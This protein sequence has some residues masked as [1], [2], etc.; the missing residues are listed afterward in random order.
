MNRERGFSLVELL[1]VITIIGILA[2]I[3]LPN[4]TKVRIKARETEVKANLHVI[5]ENIE[6]FYVDEKEYPAYL[7]GGDQNS[8][9][10]IHGVHP[11]PDPVWDNLD[12]P[13]IKYNYLSTYPRNPFTDPTTGGLYL[14]ASGGDRN[15]AASGD[16][17]F[18]VNGT[19]MPNSVDDPLVFNTDP[20]V[21]A[22]T[23][24]MTGTPS[25]VN[26]GG[27]GGRHG[28][29]GDNER[30]IIAGSFFYR[31]EGNIDMM[32]SDVTSGSPTRR[33]FLYQSY[34]RFILGG[35][36]DDAT[37]GFDVIRLEG[38][39]NYRHQ[40][41]TTTTFPWDIPLLVPEVF[42]G[43]NGGEN[44]LLPFF[45][46]E[47]SEIGT[48]FNFGAPDGYEDGVVLVV[49]SDGEALNF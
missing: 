46:Y 32:T 49:T 45:P 9:A 43:G 2:A 44:E 24:I 38:A 11:S 23:I 19:I 40:P 42:G 4:F 7:I 5:Q 20:G 31:A 10:H 37:K 13:L 34:D 16:P 3:A 48:P 41:N 14:E 47:P 29:T 33:S 6:R 21:Y 27:Y 22:Q 30:F 18:G 35:F 17:R 26:Y 12:D 28:A 1:V 25:I 8:W 39:G 36:G 15:T